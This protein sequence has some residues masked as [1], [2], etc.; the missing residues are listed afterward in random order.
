M[1]QLPLP[2]TPEQSSE[3][4]PD[5]QKIVTRLFR[6]P[7]D[8]IP[9]CDAQDYASGELQLMRNHRGDLV[10]FQVFSLGQLPEGR[11]VIK[12]GPSGVLP[13]YQGRGDGK[14]GVMKAMISAFGRHLEKLPEVFKKGS[15]A[16]FFAWQAFWPLGVVT[17]GNRAVIKNTL[18]FPWAI[19]DVEL[20]AWRDER[21]ITQAQFEEYRQ[22][23]GDASEAVYRFVGDRTPLRLDIA[24]EITSTWLPIDPKMRQA[25]TKVHLML[26]PIGPLCLAQAVRLAMK[27]PIA[28][29]F[30]LLPLAL[31]NPWERA[32]LQSLAWSAANKMGRRITDC[33][34]FTGPVS[35]LKN[36][37]SGLFANMILGQY[38]S[39]VQTASLY[40]SV[41]GQVLNF[42]KEKPLGAALTFL[43]SVLELGV[44]AAQDLLLVL[45]LLDSPASLLAVNVAS[46]ALESLCK[47]LDQQFTPRRSPSRA[48]VTP[49][50]AELPEESPSLMERAGRFLTWAIGLDEM[51]EA[52][53]EGHGPGMSF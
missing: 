44:D 29:C 53:V 6:G 36:I 23:L 25:E 48:L 31:G 50:A 46:T 17:S 33:V 13:E 9:V 42:L 35:P 51:Y 30:E 27:L 22:F 24:E 20:R 52:A 41:S 49:Q 18:S 19:S 12:F 37:V 26:F 32:V 21:Q 28:R 4:A 11:E 43:V 1:S 5:L 7:H 45:V 34:H 2:L 40:L 16:A 3:L 38:F 15:L 8:E 10:G 47:K 39:S 14:W